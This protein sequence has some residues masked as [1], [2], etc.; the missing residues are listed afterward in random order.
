[1]EL[2]EMKWPDVAALAKDTPIHLKIG[3]FHPSADSLVQ[4][5]ICLL[6]CFFKSISR[7]YL[8]ISMYIP[9]FGNSDLS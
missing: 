5:I 2:L 4:I 1:M 7:F 3:R 8:V 9:P 6:Q